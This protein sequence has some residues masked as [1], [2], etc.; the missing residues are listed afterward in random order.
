MPSW[1]SAQSLGSWLGPATGPSNLG[2]LAQQFAQM[3]PEGAYAIGQF[4]Q[5]SLTQQAQDTRYRD[6][7]AGK[8]GPVGPSWEDI[9]KALNTPVTDLPGHGAGPTFPWQQQQK[10]DQ[11]KPDASIDLSN[12]P[13]GA[14]PA[15]VQ[16]IVKA[17]QDVGVDPGLALAIAMPESGLRNP[18]YSDN[19]ASFGP[20][21][22]NAKGGEGSGL[23]LSV[24]TDPYQSSKVAL[25]EIKKQHELHPDWTPGDIAIAAQRP[26]ESLRP[27]YRDD[28]NGF[29]S[30]ISTGTG[31]LAGLNQFVAGRGSAKNLPGGGTAVPLPFPADAFHKSLTQTFREVPSEAG[32]DFAMPAGTQLVS[33]VGGKVH[34][35][36]H[37]KA[38]WGK[39]V[40]VETPGGWTIAIGHMTSFSVEDGQTISV[41]DMLGLSGGNANDP[42]SG[43]TTGD[44]IEF[45]ILDP[46]HHYVDPFPALQELFKGAKFD[47]WFGGVFQSS[48]G[49]RGQVQE[50]QWTPDHQL[51]DAKSTAGQWYQTVNSAWK[52]IYGVN[53]PFAAATAFQNAGIKT[54]QDLQNAMNQLP[55]SVPG[56]TI[57][58]YNALSNSLQGMSQDRFGRPVPQSMIGE[59]AAK[60]ITTKSDLQLWFDTHSSSDIPKDQYQSVYDSASGYVKGVWGDV[61]HP[62]DV[63][64]AWK[65]AG[66][67]G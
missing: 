62:T 12:L 41:G 52:S 35:E 7:L 56:L 25:T 59:M 51:I 33:P 49:V 39:R 22:L 28:I 45:Q 55:S 58:A 40:F 27:K 8:R 53:A 9:W 16:A 14:D 24:L 54:V 48:A 65:K 3:G 43:V 15:V 60:G 57:G 30:Q 34:L 42:S 2:S 1:L 20:F 67:G 37:G 64:A 44:H 36:D 6:R 38:D 13:E 4:L 18:L 5:W 26:L 11:Q 50:L 46:Q 29:Y 47:K 19:G 61:P 32:N 17:A 23:P 31:K 63:A 66:G 21:Q 10:P